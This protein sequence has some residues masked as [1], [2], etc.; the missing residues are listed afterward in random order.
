MR[1][2][3]NATWASGQA[4]T[5]V[6]RRVGEALG[7]RAIEMTRPN[8][9]ILLLA[10]KGHNGDD[11]RAAQPHLPERRVELLNV[12]DPKAALKKF[13]ERQSDFALV[14][15]GLF[16]V[17]LDRPLD[18]GW[19]ELINTVNASHIPI[20][21]ADVPSGL[22]ANTGDHFG[23][24][25]RARVTLTVGAPK[26]GLLETAAAE[27]VGRL[28]VAADVGLIPCP[29]R[30]EMDWT[31]AADFKGFP[32]PR[33]VIGHKGTFGHLGIVAGSMGFHGAAVLASRGAQRAR[34]GLITLFAHESV[35]YPV[36]VQ[37]Q[38]AMVHPWEANSNLIN[39]LEKFSAIL[40]GP[41]LAATDL[42]EEIK[43]P[44]RRYWREFQSPMIVDASALDWLTQGAIVKDALR[45]ITPHPGEAA[46]LLRSTVE[47][48]Q[49]HRAEAVRELSRRFGN[50]WVV[51]KGHQ[52]LVGRSTGEIFV[53]SSGNPNLAQGGSGDVLSGYLAGLLAQPLLEPEIGRAIRYAV[54]QHGATADWLDKH[55]PNWIIEDLLEHLGMAGNAT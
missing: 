10:G 51:L 15:D 31:L 55:Q 33:P 41:G 52:T 21:A 14:I 36:A 25:I 49:Q 48:V 4:E 26:E 46:R 2:W 45:V 12:D 3:E 32:P 17:G 11:V 40:V 13:Q 8:D 24:A 7:R 37:L 28:E 30:P 34:P 20:L 38:S 19:Q 16:G 9:L 35:Y 44:V 47:K 18:A 53:N 5:E 22:N 6:I 50:C 43:T 39:L 23:T 1:D 42:P 29:H 27:F 54:W